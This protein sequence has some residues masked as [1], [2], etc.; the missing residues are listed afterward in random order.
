L[1]RVWNVEPDHIPHDGPPTHVMEMVRLMEEGEIGFFW[2]SA[3]NPLVSLPE[4][5]RIREVLARD[6]VFVVVPALF[7]TETAAVADI[8]LPAATQGRRRAP[9]RTPTARSTSRSRRSTRRG[10]GA[11]TS[12]SGSTTRAGWASATA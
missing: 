8:V 7:L 3:T 6:E 10:R 11:P 4:A 1:A 2:I 5:R 12:T 9:S